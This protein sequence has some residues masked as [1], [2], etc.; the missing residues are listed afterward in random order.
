MKEGAQVN[1]YGDIEQSIFQLLGD[2]Q[3]TGIT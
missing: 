2:G 1:T 3:E